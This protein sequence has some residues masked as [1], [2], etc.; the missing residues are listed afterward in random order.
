MLRTFR[1]GRAASASYPAADDLNRPPDDESF[2]TGNGFAARCGTVLN[3]GRA[4]RND[5]GRPD[6]CYCKTDFLDAFFERHAPPHEFVLFSHNSDYP[7]DDARARHVRDR[8][9]RVWFAA[10]LAADNP[11]L[12]PLPLGIANPSWPHG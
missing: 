12:R 3:Y 5:E 10:N 2:I 6:W 1:R 8:R 7:V 11:K 4:R 9:L